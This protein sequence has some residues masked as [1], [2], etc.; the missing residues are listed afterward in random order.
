[1]QFEVLQPRITSQIGEEEVLTPVCAR[2][3][4]KS[5]AGTP[6]CLV[7]SKIHY[8]WPNCPVQARQAQARVM[9]GI[10]AQ[11]YYSTPHPWSEILVLLASF[12]PLIRTVILGPSYCDPYSI[13][14]H[15]FPYTA[16]V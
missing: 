3:A 14:R 8:S 6:D 9:S 1:M 2:Q 7:E 5:N 12:L 16:N 15:L 11:C 4:R 13:V 10:D